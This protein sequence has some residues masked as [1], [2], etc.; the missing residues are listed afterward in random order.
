[1]QPPGDLSCAIGGRRIL[2]I[3]TEDVGWVH[4]R[5]VI[6]VEADSEGAR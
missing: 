2:T 3:V 1:L 4:R 5:E 6:D